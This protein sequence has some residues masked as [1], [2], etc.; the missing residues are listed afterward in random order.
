MDAIPRVLVTGATGFVGRWVVRELAAQGHFAL[1][2]VR[3]RQKVEPLIRQYG[4]DR[5]QAV[6]ADLFDEASVA[7]A[8]NGSDA[9]IH[10]VGIIAEDARRGQTFERLHVL[11]TRRVVDACRAAKVPRYIH[12]SA[13][14]AR[15]QAVSAYH[16]TKAVAEDYV[17]QSDLAWTIFRPSLIHGPDG[18]FMRL[19]RRLACGTFI[20]VMPHFG[21]GLARI[22]PVSVQDVAY[23]L[24]AAVTKPETIGGI[25]ELGGP[26]AMTWRELYRT[27][28]ELMP[29]ACRRRPIVGQP[30]F[31]AKLLATTLMRLPIVPAGLRFNLDQVQISQEDS[32]CDSNRIEQV[33]G[34][35][36][37][38][39]REE[40]ARY[41]PTM[42]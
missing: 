34:L 26:R 5:V 16:R 38:D 36:L 18:E 22:Q 37:R 27:C 32:V 14:G 28:Q 31:L 6:E 21:D 13:L 2:L 40:L 35:K 7:N 10:L 24:V 42:A 20:P 25:Y 29:G 33:F 41:A 23:C 11:A 30:V 12:M 1:C 15:A 4:A 17:R 3:D 39:F 8:A 9:V 19:M